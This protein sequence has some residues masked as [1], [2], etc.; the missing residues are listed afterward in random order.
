MVEIEK[1]FIGTVGITESIINKDKLW[2]N[3]FVMHPSKQF[4]GSISRL[5]TNRFKR[6]AC[7]PLSESN[8]Y[9]LQIAH[10]GTL[11]YT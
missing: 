10:K 9:C 6:C 8:K 1:A 3:Y 11:S 7:T 5:N 2:R 4:M